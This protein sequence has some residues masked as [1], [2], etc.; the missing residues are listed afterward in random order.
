MTCSACVCLV[1]AE[2]SGMSMALPTLHWLLAAAAVVPPPLQCSSNASWTFGWGLTDGTRT[3]LRAP[4]TIAECCAACST[5]NGS[6]FACG[7]WTWHA[8]GGLGME[9]LRST[10]CGGRTR[11]R[12][13]GNKLQ[14]HR[15][16][17]LELQ[18]HR[19]QARSSS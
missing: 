5:N 12:R 7:A 2:T 19:I 10:T 14:P 3:Y 13:S 11:M 9:T 8:V 6:L 17:P 1:R 16:R 15:L 4:R 18:L